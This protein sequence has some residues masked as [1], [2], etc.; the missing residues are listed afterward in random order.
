M[1]NYRARGLSAWPI[2]EGAF[3]RVEVALAQLKQV[4]L[5]VA[6][7]HD[8]WVRPGPGDELIG[9]LPQYLPPLPIMLVSEGAYP[10]AYAPFQTDEFLRLLPTVQLQ[11]FEIDL[12]QPPE[13]EDADELPF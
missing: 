10:R 6:F 8:S 4:R 13:D 3:L 1:R 11:R 12:S 5:I 7:P 2:D 9:R